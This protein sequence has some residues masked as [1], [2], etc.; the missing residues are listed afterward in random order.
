MACSILNSSGLPSTPIMGRNE[1]RPA[2]A[3]P[4]SWKL[5]QHRWTRAERFGLAQQREGPNAVARFAGQSA[6]TAGGRIAAVYR[7]RARTRHRPV[8]GR[9]RR[10]VSGAER[11]PGRE[12]RRMADADRERAWRVQGAASGEESSALCGQPDLPRLQRPADEGHGDL[13]EAPGS[14]HY[15][16]AAP[17]AGNRRGRAFLWRRGVP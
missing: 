12:T 14:D 11:A 3:L 8:Q 5:S 16:L 15:H 10:L 2:E 1:Q 13:R 7:V 4:G 6:R 17:A 9:H